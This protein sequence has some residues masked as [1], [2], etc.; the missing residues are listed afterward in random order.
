[1]SMWPVRARAVAVRDLVHDPLCA[2]LHRCEWSPCNHPMLKRHL[3]VAQRDPSLP[4]HGYVRVHYKEAVHDPEGDTTTELWHPVMHNQKGEKITDPKG[5]F[6]MASNL[7]IDISK[8]PRPEAW[9]HGD[10]SDAEGLQR[11]D[12]WKKKRVM[13][14]I[15]DFRITNL[16]A[17]KQDQWRALNE[18]HNRYRRSDEVPTL[19]LTI[20]SGT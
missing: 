6:F 9:K 7:V 17:E 16:P 8:P 18:F 13:S 19:P 2:A 14:D 3:T 20:R 12:V 4:E 15:L 5:I 11:K 1:M 10:Y